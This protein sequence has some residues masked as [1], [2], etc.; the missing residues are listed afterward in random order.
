MYIIGNGD[1]MKKIATIND[2]SGFG[3]CSLG[4]AMPIISTM[5]VQC[6]PLTTGVFSNQT[7][8][9]SYR[10]VDFTE[11]ME[12]FIAEWKKLDAHFDGIITGF[13]PNSRQGQIISSFID[14]FK[15]DG[16]IV[17]VDP[18]MGDNGVLYPCYDKDSI[19]AV[20]ELVKKA[21]IITP[22]LT[23][24]CCL[25]NEDYNS[26]SSLPIKILVEK[27]ADMSKALGMSVVTTGIAVE[28]EIVTTVYTDNDMQIVKC[29]KIG[30]SFS[31]TGDILASI[32]GAGVVNGMSIID[33]TRLAG[34]FI[35][36]SIK[37][38]IKDTNGEYNPADGIHFESQLHSLGGQYGK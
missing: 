5:G 34:Q 13:I 15:E 6:C 10:S 12:D 36:D 26:I 4:V 23:E 16:T 18:I 33:A 32:V 7:G 27:V 24:L 38:T 8:Y 37:Q 31:G 22:N 1:D 28:D 11:Y 9:P 25:A 30:G 3:K 17:L 35:T 14:R 20:K 29:K 19:N 21:D 2:L